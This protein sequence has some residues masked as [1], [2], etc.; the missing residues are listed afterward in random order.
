MD[1][2]D[3]PFADIVDE[4]SEK[5]ADMEL[6]AREQMD[7][8]RK[9]LRDMPSYACPAPCNHCCHGSILMSYVEYISIIAALRERGGREKIAELFTSRLGN[10]EAEGKLLC[11]F[12]SE[13]K[14]AEH[15]AI[16][17][18]RPLICR[19]FGT[20]ASPCEEDITHPHFS[21]ATFYRTYN[22]L[23]YMDDGSFIGLPL[24]E[25]L[26]LYEAPFDIWAIAD[27]GQTMELMAIFE[28]HG[29]M[30][31]VIC[32]LPQDRFFTILPGG[33]HLY[34]DELEPDK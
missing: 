18:H 6:Y 1:K 27:S 20:S 28:Q 34:L 17:D 25:T 24:T 13:E 10:M 12:V 21:E 7:S 5:T 9:M 3:F 19:V 11:P 26:A 16:Y 23:Y 32:N 4:V 2:L 15:C 31:A 30:R 33:G 8:M 29:S 14:D 22:N